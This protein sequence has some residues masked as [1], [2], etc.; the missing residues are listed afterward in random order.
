MKTITAMLAASLTALTPPTLALS[1][2]WP[3]F[4]G[5][6]HDASVEEPIR[7]DW[8]KRPPEVLW[9]AELGIGCVAFSIAG[10]RAL[11]LGNA[12]DQDTLWCLDAESGKV[13]WK[14]A[15][16][17]PLADKQYTGG[18]S[19]QPTIDG[20]RVYS[21]SKEGKL[22][23]LEL[24]TGKL[25][26]SKN[27]VTDFGGRKSDWG[28]S[29]SPRV[30]GDMLL[31]DPGAEDGAIAALDKMTGAVLWK[32]GDEKPGY[33]APAIFRHNGRQMAAFF[34]AKGLVVYDLDAKGAI[35]FSYRWRTNWGVNASNPQYHDN[36]LF[37]ASGYGQGYAILDVSAAEPQLLHRDRDMELMFQNSVFDG[38]H[39]MAVF[40]D[41]GEPARLARLDIASGK[42][43]WRH[44]LPGERG[45][46]L[47][48]G[49]HL[50]ILAETGDLVFGKADDAG[51]K[52]V[53]RQK[54]LAELCW[55]PP[56]LSNGRLYLRNN[57][58]AAVCLDVRP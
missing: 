13:L 8:E 48:A 6:R 2:D 36:R 37:L 56:S 14:H 10:N 39:I 21:L 27:Y 19:A 28:W 42:V 4:L 49:T 52:E 44:D 18:P 26:W 32:A 30:L 43:H 54:V 24:A 1:E 34:H 11:S 40:E 25:L 15:Y 29:A 47:R 12:N 55:A 35:V 57:A 5:P 33:A 23:C 9:K 31:I 16:A 53:A 22:F 20:D 3:H 51:F 50:I 41:K 58:G 38:N 17:E 46:L 7:L 45:S